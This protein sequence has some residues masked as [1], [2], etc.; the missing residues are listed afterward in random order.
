MTSRLGSAEPLRSAHITASWGSSVSS[1]PRVAD[2]ME[3][4][5]ELGRVHL[6]HLRST[7]CRLNRFGTSNMTMPNRIPFPLAHSSACTRLLVGWLSARLP[8]DGPRRLPEP[9][10]RAIDAGSSVAMSR[11]CRDARPPP[12]E[13]LWMAHRSLSVGPTH[14]A[15]ASRRA[16]PSGAS[17]SSTSSAARGLDAPAPR[18]RGV[19]PRHSLVIAARADCRH[20]GHS[21]SCGT[22]RAG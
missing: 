9:P 12:S 13:L 11:P 2:P 8:P 10:R 18:R 20:G 15:N 22:P 4:R 5:V 21:R 1:E 16:R 17:S 14:C 6:R 7:H 3:H 19:Y